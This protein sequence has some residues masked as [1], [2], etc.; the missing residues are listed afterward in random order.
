MGPR[1]DFDFLPEEVLRLAGQYGFAQFRDWQ[2]PTQQEVTDGI[3][4]M[5]DTCKADYDR[6]SL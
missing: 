2:W 6:V 3:T 4:N 5:P 1:E